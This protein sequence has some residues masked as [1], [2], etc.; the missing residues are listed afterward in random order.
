MKNS[1][2]LKKCKVCGKK[3]KQYNSLQNKCPDCQIKE[4][5]S[6]S[7]PKKLKINHTVKKKR[8]D[9]RR[10]EK[11][12]DALFQKAGKKIYPKSLISGQPTEVIHHFVPKSQSN[13]LRYDFLNAIPLLN[14]EHFRHHITGDPSIMATVIRKKGNKWEDDLNTRRHITVKQTEERLRQVIEELETIV[15]GK[16]KKLPF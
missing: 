15:Y 5:Y 6:H 1:I 16:P 3:F 2:D 12:A 11:Y 7:K 13:N 10:L 4:F 14:S 9:I 8:E